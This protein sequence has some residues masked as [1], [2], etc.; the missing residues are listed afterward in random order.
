MIPIASWIAQQE[1]SG[2]AGGY[3][4]ADSRGRIAAQLFIES[5]LLSLAGAACGLVLAAWG[6]RLLISFLPQSEVPLAFDLHPGS[7][8]LSFTVAIAV[9]TA[10]LFGLGP[11]AAIPIWICEPRGASLVPLPPEGC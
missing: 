4:R 3:G 7:A 1:R 11:A 2:V 8:I 6:A 9:A 10:V 5:L